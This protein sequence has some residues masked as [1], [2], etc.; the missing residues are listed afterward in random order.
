M[1]EG[2]DPTEE[3]ADAIDRAALVAVWDALAPLRQEEELEQAE[4]TRAILAAFMAA[5]KAVRESEAALLKEHPEA[6][7][8]SHFANEDHIVCSA[9][10]AEIC[11][12][13]SADEIHPH[14]VGGNKIEA[15]LRVGR[16]LEAL[17]ALD[18]A[19]DAEDD[20]MPGHYLAE[21]LAAHI[22]DRKRYV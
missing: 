7:Y 11:G 8:V 6:E 4:Q 14:S 20:T 16:A 1:R 13:E 2:Y 22:E 15:L 18:G 17:S 21:V 12:C 3:E 10:H 19:L 9:F 5:K